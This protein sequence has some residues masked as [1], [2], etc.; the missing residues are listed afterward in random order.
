MSGTDCGAGSQRT[1][2]AVIAGLIENGELSEIFQRLIG[3]PDKTT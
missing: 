3:V 2:A 1:S